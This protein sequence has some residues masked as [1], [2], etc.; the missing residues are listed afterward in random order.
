MGRGLSLPASVTAGARAREQAASATTILT[1]RTGR[2]TLFFMISP[3]INDSSFEGAD[4][5]IL[6]RTYQSPSPKSIIKFVCNPL[7]TRANTAII[8]P[9]PRILERDG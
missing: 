3:W 5:R 9:V 8:A 2:A 1:G 4:K 7:D 6:A